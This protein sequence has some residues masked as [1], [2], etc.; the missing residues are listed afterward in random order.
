MSLD[1]L[2][3][4]MERALASNFYLLALTTALSVP[5]IAAAIDSDN[6]RATRAKYEKWYNN[7]VLPR[8]SINVKKMLEKRGHK[9]LGD[10]ENPF[11]GNECYYYR[12]AMLHQARST[13]DKSSFSRVMFIEPNTTTNVI[14]YGKMNDALTIDL[15]SFCLEVAQGYRSWV[16]SAKG[17]VNY[18]R[19]IANT[20]K[21]YSN[22]L[23]PYIVGVPIIS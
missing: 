8:F 16:S 1:A 22:G 11:N 18:E 3:E 14:H 4:Q 19:N 12:C 17:T 13:H 23:S 21:R 9:Y 6:G 20:M 2:V 10:I 7:W 15:P 5:D